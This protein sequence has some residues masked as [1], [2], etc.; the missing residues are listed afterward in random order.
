MRLGGPIYEKPDTPEAWVEAHRA[1]GFRAAT[2]PLTPEADDATVRAYADAATKADLVIAEVGAWSN[3]LAPNEDARAKAVEKS[4]RCLDLADRIGARC[5][6]N[7]PGRSGPATQMDPSPF[8]AEVF[9]MIVA[10][11]R[12]IIDAVKPTRTV[13]TLET[14]PRSF[15]D[16]PEIYLDLI[17]AIDRPGFGAHLDPINLISSP[18]AF[19]INAK[20]LRESIRLLA[21]HVVSCHVKDVTLKGSSRELVHLDECMPGKGQMDLAAYL[22][23]LGRLDSDLP[24]MMEHLDSAEEYDEAAAHLRAVAKTEGVTL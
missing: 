6:V 1:H 17:E 2:C 15:P 8:S 5:C 13:Y 9:D 7:I 3:P 10:S 14:Q 12:E 20:I 18:R 19:Y 11:V 23:E 4:R 24:L 22:R 21:P 16:T